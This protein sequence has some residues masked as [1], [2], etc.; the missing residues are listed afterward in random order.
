MKQF[1]VKVVLVIPVKNNY[2]DFITVYDK[3]WSLSEF[4]RELKNF[5]TAYRKGDPLISDR[6]YD[7]L[8]KIL[9]EQ[10][11]DHEWFS[12]IE[13]SLIPENRK[14]KLPVQ[15]KSLNKVVTIDE[16]QAWVKTCGL[17]GAHKLVCMPKF[18]GGSLLVTEA[19]KQGYS[20]G[21]AEN[22]GQNCDIHLVQAGI[23]TSE[24][25]Q[26]TFGEFVITVDSWN[27]N[28]KGQINP[29]SGLEYKAPRNVAVGMLNAE[30]PPKKIVNAT[31]FRYGISGWH[32]EYSTF[33]EQIKDICDTYG[34]PHLY[35]TT[36]VKDITHDLLQSL[37]DQWSKI[38]G[39]DGIV[40]YIDNL[41]LSAKI[42]RNQSSGNP[43][44]AVA[45]KGGF[46][47]EVDTETLSVSVEVSKNGYLRP[48]VQIEPVALS[49]ST[50]TNP[51]GNNM[52]FIT[53][54]KIA[55]GAIIKVKRSGEVIPKIIGVPTPATDESMGKLLDSLSVCPCC[56]KPTQWNDT[57]TDIMCVNPECSGIQFAKLLHFYLTIGCDGL[58]KEIFSKL[59]E[60]G[61]NSI[62]K[63]LNVTANDVIA[64]DRLGMSSAKI[65]IDLNQKI[66]AGLPLDLLIHASDCF[67]GIGRK[68]A[69]VLLNKFEV[70]NVNHLSMLLFQSNRCP[71]DFSITEA[72]F[73]DGIPQFLD[74]L[75]DNSLTALDVE[76]QPEVNENGKF[77]GFSVCFTGIRDKD[78]EAYIIS[79]GGSIASGV[80]KK[81]THLVVKEK[82]SSSSKTEKAKQLG[83]QIFD[84][85]EFKD[86][87]I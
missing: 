48:T 28:F 33:T 66:K 35:F 4:I 73:Y 38:F 53:D 75:S 77:N 61:F 22:E 86:R 30:I 59:F 45:Y 2:M 58:G 70:S 25:F 57:R 1:V 81:T 24:K 27:E 72:A 20:R 54:N 36:D 18:D 21:G 52:R 55:A 34:Q 64:I 9:K 17:R 84:I 42:G 39:I 23:Q 87:F 83:I 32:P 71:A 29:K 44:Y 26:Y 40:L 65:L 46:E 15:M 11:P 74:F 10:Y 68:K 12:Q 37:Y 19:T 49:N 50:I 41:E 14:V 51:T 3:Q 31:F 8:T 80:S 6:Q 56:G 79:E 78:L 16:F 67:V 82:S 76:L 47:E 13:P 7:T 62:Y 5:N 43:M 85:N 60:S 69:M 63:M